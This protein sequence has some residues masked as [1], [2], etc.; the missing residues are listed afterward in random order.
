MPFIDTSNRSG[1][2]V[3]PGRFFAGF[4]RALSL[5]LLQG[6]ECAGEAASN[7]RAGG[8]TR[9]GPASCSLICEMN[10]FARLCR[11]SG[12]VPRCPPCGAGHACGCHRTLFPW[13]MISQ[14]REGGLWAGVNGTEQAPHAD[15]SGRCTSCGGVKKQGRRILFPSSAWLQRKQSPALPLK[16]Q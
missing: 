13:A 7:A 8:R 14:G 16:R 2:A 12:I 15:A 1:T 10:R 9:C 4:R 5:M 6:H 11:R 3:E